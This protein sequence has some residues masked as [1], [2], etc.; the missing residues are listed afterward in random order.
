MMLWF[1]VWWKYILLVMFLGCNRWFSATN[2]PL[3]KHYLSWTKLKPLLM[4]RAPRI[5][6]LSV[7][8]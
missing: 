1:V 2:I 3:A 6:L 4:L 5:F 8:I 7:E